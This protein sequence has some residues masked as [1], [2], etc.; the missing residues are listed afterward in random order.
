MNKYL[1]LKIFILLSLTALV[2]TGCGRKTAQ[3][4]QMDR[5]DSL[6]DFEEEEDHLLGKFRRTGCFGDC[7]VF[8]VLFYTGGVAIFTGENFVENLGPHIGHYDEGQFRKIIDYAFEKGFFDLEE[9]YPVDRRDFIPDLSNT[10]TTLVIKKGSKT[11]DHNNSGPELLLEIE[12]KIQALIDKIEWE[13][14]K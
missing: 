14:R 7:P 5:I 6:N 3:I 1:I 4:A 11:V 9:F 8:R 10:L 13:E 12:Q 2:A